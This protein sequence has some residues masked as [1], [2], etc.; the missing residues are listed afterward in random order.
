MPTVFRGKAQVTGSLMVADVILYPTAESLDLD[1]DF[2]MDIVQDEG[3]DDQAWRSR[4]EKYNGDVGMVLVDKSSSSTIAHAQAG[5]AFFAPF[6][7]LTIST[8]LVAAWNTTFVIM[9]GSKITQK[10][11]D[12][13]K[14]MFKLRRYADS[15]QNTLFAT[16]PS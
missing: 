6:A 13:G 3:G 1:H 12:T 14:I 5:A 16:T 7:V 11:N 4:N 10:N 8:C 9:P 2:E 15:T